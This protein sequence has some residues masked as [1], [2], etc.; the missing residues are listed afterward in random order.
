M[1]NCKDCIYFKETFKGK[2]YCKLWQDYVKAD[3]N[4]EEGEEE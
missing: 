1:M 2:G 4:C 3:D